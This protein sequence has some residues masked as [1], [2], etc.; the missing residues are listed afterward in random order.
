[1]TLTANFAEVVDISGISGGGK[2]TIPA[3]SDSKGG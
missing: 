1:M 2:I 3:L